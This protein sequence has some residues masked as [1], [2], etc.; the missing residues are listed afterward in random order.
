[1]KNILLPFFIAMA[2][3]CSGCVTT[4][5]TFYAAKADQFNLKSI[6][7]VNKA[8]GSQEMDDRI[9]RELE[10]RNIR[11]VLGPETNK[12]S[13]EDAIMKYNET[14]KTELST[15]LRALDIL[16]YDPNGELIA[17]SHWENSKVSTLASVSSIVKDSV[18]VIPISYDA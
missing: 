4:V 3:V 2:F 11:V 1:M 14:W 6:Y 10:R 12:V 7:L 16:L 13:T 8:A 17:T 18:G 9:K 15:F 5:D